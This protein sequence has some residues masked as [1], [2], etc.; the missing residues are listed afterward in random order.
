MLFDRSAK[1]AF[2]VACLT[3]I[4]SGLAFQT[5]VKNLNIYLRKEPVELRHHFTTISRTLGDWHAVTSDLQL[6]AATIESL[7]TDIYLD[8]TYAINGEQSEGWLHLHM[9]YYTGMI[10]AIPHVPDRCM[11]AGG[12]N[13]LTLPTY[14][15]L[16][17]DTSSWL[18]D[19]QHINQR[20]RKPYPY[21]HH[22]DPVR[23]N[24]IMVRMPIG[25][26]RLRTTEFNHPQMGDSRVYAG[27]F[28]IANGHVTASPYNVR[29]LAFDRTDQYAYYMKVQFTT[30][31]SAE[32]TQEDF[33][34][35]V[36]DILPHLLPEIMRCLPDW[37]ELEAER[38]AQT[39]AE[40]RQSHQ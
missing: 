31:G 39:L 8:R 12:F 2:V 6:D 9:A 17:I 3:L 36:T 21:V 1:I 15:G 22:R 16:P 14:V 20:S 34:A 23:G 40:A 7:G 26:Y 32:L 37:A 35:M 19:E 29:R 27:F 10:D 38:Q 13:A 28:F 33:A 5:A 25:E 18:L 11:V 4:G 30:Y 24:P